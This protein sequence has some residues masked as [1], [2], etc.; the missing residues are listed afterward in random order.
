MNGSTTAIKRAWIVWTIAIY[1]SITSASLFA[2][3]EPVLAQ[4]ADNRPRV[5]VVHP[6]RA[7]IARRLK[8]NATLEA[9]EEADLFAKVSGYLSEVRVDIGDHVKA[10]DVLAMISIP[11]MDKELAE[12]DAQL[13]V[14]QRSLDSASR[15][16][17]HAK[18]D[19]AL[20]DIT[21]KR[22]ES[23]HQGHAITDQALDEIRAKTQIARADLGIADAKRALAAAQVDSAAAAVAKIKTLIA[24]TQITAPFDG[25]VSRRLVNRGDLVQAATANRT[26]PLFTL[27]RI[28]VIRVFCDVPEGSVPYLRAGDTAVVKPIGFDGASFEGKVTRFAFRLNPETRNMRTEIDLANSQEQLYPGMYAEVAL[29]MDRRQN[30]LTVPASAVGKD[31]DGSFV[32]T[33]IDDHI[34]RRGIKAGISDSGRVEVI[35]G[36]PEDALVVATAKGAP[37]P[38]TAVQVASQGNKS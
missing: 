1:L 6:T 26:M 19:V 22:Q 35:E 32:L 30:A 14:R 38:G 27:Q 10:G 3:A 5:D 2:A 18:A 37:P 15:E 4:S 9:F 12:A 8:T 24:Y 13:A 34:E 23:L 16:V 21:L 29:E 31:A 7:T 36:L 11:E 20:Q 25:V 17:D 33:V 28:N